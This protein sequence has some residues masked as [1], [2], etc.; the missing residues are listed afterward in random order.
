MLAAPDPSRCPL[1]AAPNGCAIQAGEDAAACWCM[2]AAIAAE[3]QAQIPET[4]RNKACLC[5]KCAAASP[6]EPRPLRTVTR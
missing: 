4:A 3:V 2:S 6:T 1:C 5:A